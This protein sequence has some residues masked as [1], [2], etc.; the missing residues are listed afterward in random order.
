MTIDERIEALTMGMEL[1]SRNQEA[2]Q[3]AQA[4]TERS[5]QRWAALGVTEARKQRKRQQEIDLNITR[6]SAAQLITEERM[7]ELAE[8]QRR[9]EESMRQTDQRMD[10]LILAVDEIV[11]GRNGG[12]KAPPQ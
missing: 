3:A 10:A 9:T 4:K 6:L 12:S 1:L 2:M 11:R 8:A 5:L 7:K